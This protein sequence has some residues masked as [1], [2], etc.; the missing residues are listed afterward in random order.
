MDHWLK[1][2][3]TAVGSAGGFLDGGGSHPLQEAAVPLLDDAHVQQESEAIRQ[4]FG[5]SARSC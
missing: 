2:V 1:S 5:K 4:C 3:I